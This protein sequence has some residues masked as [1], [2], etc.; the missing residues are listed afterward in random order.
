M[1]G[2]FVFGIHL[3]WQMIAIS[4]KL[5]ETRALVHGLHPCS[6]YLCSI[7]PPLFDCEL[8]EMRIS[9]PDVIFVLNGLMTQG[10]EKIRNK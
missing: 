1:L 10:I 5:N 9:P 2:H 6:T 4:G 3:T 7:P 8:R